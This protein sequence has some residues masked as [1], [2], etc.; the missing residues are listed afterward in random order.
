MSSIKA[1]LIGNPTSE[2]GSL[3][4]LPDTEGLNVLSREQLIDQANLRF[5]K[6]DKVCLTTESVLDNVLPRLDDK[7]RISAVLSLKDKF[8]FRELLKNIYPDFH[9]VQSK[10]EELSQAIPTDG[11]KF[12]IKP[13][14]GC[15]GSGVRVVEGDVD[16]HQLINEI[17]LELSKN[18][19]VLSD[20]VLTPDEFLIES[21]IE[22]EEYAVDMFY[23]KDG[24]PMITNIYHHPMPA[25]P[26][27][28]HMLYYSI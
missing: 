16:I 1:Y 24:I 15:F 9:F 7:N 5:G 8:A 14:K 19:A 13:V 11:S 23:N 4:T 22:G 27:Y 3:D 20:D 12:V 25:N 6:D 21:F 28:L 18:S 17:Q 10:L 2:S 26:A